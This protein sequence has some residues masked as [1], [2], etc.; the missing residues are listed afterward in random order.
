M[1]LYRTLPEDIKQIVK[2]YIR[3]NTYF[4]YSENVLLEMVA[5]IDNV[6]R[7]KAIGLM[8]REAIVMVM[9]SLSPIP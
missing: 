9:E 5:D 3:R 2:P 7:K 4:A 8:V 1:K 6:M